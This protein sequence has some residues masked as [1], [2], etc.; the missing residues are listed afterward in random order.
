MW[1]LWLTVRV[2][3]ASGLPGSK[4][5]RS[6]SRPALL[7]EAEGASR[8]SAC[9]GRPPLVSGEGRVCPGLGTCGGKTSLLDSPGVRC[10][11]GGSQARRECSWAGCFVEAGSTGCFTVSDEFDVWVLRVGLCQSSFPGPLYVE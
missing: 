7:W 6:G 9:C 11:R 5:K 2:P 1:N 10:W 4:E 3:P 8:P